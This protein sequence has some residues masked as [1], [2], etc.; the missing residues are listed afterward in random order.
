MT[1]HS[2]NSRKLNALINNDH[3][4]HKMTKRARDKLTGHGASFIKYLDLILTHSLIHFAK[5]KVHK[6]FCPK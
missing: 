3:K 6:Y 5:T 1:A 4:M 2:K